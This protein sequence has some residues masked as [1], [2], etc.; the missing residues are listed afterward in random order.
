MFSK[1]NR[2]RNSYTK[3]LLNSIETIEANIQKYI[4]DS[5]VRCRWLNNGVTIQFKEPNINKIS[6]DQ[7]KYIINQT[8]KVF[9]LSKDRIKFSEYKKGSAF[10]PRKIG[11]KNA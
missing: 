10:I 4:P 11:N 9:S 5:D 7:K 1:Q 6:I 8:T 2:N 3:K